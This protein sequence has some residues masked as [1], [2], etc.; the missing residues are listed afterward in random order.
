M[1][2]RCERC[3]FELREEA[4]E[5][6]NYTV[7]NDLVHAPQVGEAGSFTVEAYRAGRF[8][9][10]IWIGVDDGFGDTY[11]ECAILEPL[12]LAL[13][14]AHLDGKNDREVADRQLNQP[15]F[16]RDVQ[17][18]QATEQ[19]PQV[20]SLAWLKRFDDTFRLCRHT[21]NHL[22]KTGL[23][24]PREN[25]EPGSD[26][27]G[28]LAF[29]GKHELKGQEVKGGSHVVDAVSGD[30]RQTV[31]GIHNDLRLINPVEILQIEML[32]KA[33][34]F[35][36][37]V[38]GGRVKSLKVM[39]RPF[40]FPEWTI[41]WAGQGVNLDGRQTNDPEGRGDSGTQEGRLGEGSP[42]GGEPEGLNY[43]PTAKEVGQTSP[44]Q[45]SAGCSAKRTH[46]GSPEDA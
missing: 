22:V 25:R 9:L 15:M 35:V 39:P 45:R 19:Y 38:G 24:P 17:R 6:W 37:K 8:W 43:R 18:V 16:V 3:I 28:A 13:E 31:R 12:A 1:S 44:R 41:K 33:V 10:E 14:V 26:R 7:S 2:G 20:A 32:G 23:I 11:F 30:K 5:G 46:S 29:S 40:E 4:R 36:P 34:R 21:G 27:Y 42:Q